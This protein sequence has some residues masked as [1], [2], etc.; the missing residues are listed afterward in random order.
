MQPTWIL[1]ADRARARILEISDEEPLTEIACFASPESRVRARDTTT[2]RLP[3]TNE[4]ASAAR[5]AIEPHTP[6]R[7]KSSQRFARLLGDALGRGRDEHRYERLVL[8]AP[9]RFLGSLHEALDEPLRAC[10]VQE[11]GHDLTTLP[12][13]ALRERLPPAA[14]R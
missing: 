2:H 14:L 8:V 7:Q 1:V 6:L 3:R 10:V 11:I 12:I 4:S 13:H 5:H 9:P